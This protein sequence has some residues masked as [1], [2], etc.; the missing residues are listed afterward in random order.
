M[1]YKSFIALKEQHGKSQKES[2]DKK[3]G[4]RPKEEP[5][6]KIKGNAKDHGTMQSSHAR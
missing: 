6:S 3:E 1:P 4:G 2:K 5:K